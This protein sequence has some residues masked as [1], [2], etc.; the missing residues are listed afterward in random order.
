MGRGELPIALYWVM[1]AVILG[2][3]IWT[4]RTIDLGFYILF[5]ILVILGIVYSI[6]YGGTTIG[7]TY[8]EQLVKHR[9][10]SRIDEKIEEIGR[11]ID[12]LS[13]DIEEI[14]KLL[15]E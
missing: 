4:L 9:D 1:V 3:Y 11:K 12:N 6:V 14:K 13:K 15:E 8:V 10:L 5:T 2:L 7:T